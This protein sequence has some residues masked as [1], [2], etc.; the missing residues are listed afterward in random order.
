[1]KRIAVLIVH[2]VEIDDPEFAATPIRLLKKEFT[3]HLGRD[4]PDPEEALVFQKA[5]L[6]PVL[7]DQQ[8]A[9][10]EKACPG[11]SEGFFT[12]LSRLVRKITSGSAVATLPL[13]AAMLRRTDPVLPSVHYPT[14]RW[15]MAHFLGD[16]IAYQITPSSREIYDEVHRAYADA[17]R[18]LARRAGGEA[19]LCVV[20]HSFGT[21]VSSD[22]FY[23]RETEGQTKKP[24]APFVKR[25]ETPLERGETLTWLYTMGSPMA[26]WSLRYPAA[27]LGAPI[28]VPAPAM[29]AQELHGEWV[30][31]IDDDDLFAWPLRQ[32]GPEYASALTDRRVSVKAPPVRW[33]PL[34][35]PFYWADR[36]VMAPIA[37]RL[38]DAWRALQ[39]APA[40]RAAG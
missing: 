7:E 24:L 28:A 11:G 21:I 15:V 1:M 17:L 36:D 2:G 39:N 23:D 40:E 31:V 22:F 26:L 34:V 29:E 27:T 25:A 12:H 35:H 10:F 13:V 14:A 5:H 16:A 9:F 32:L 8:R 33:T 30:N 3:R 37:Q 20:A 18:A 38:A 4:A 19:P 6:A